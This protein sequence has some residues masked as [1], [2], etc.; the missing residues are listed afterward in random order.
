MGLATLIDDVDCREC[1]EE[2]VYMDVKEEPTS[3]KIGAYCH[4]C[5][6]DYG[7][8]TKVSRT[9]AHIDEIYEIGEETITDI[10]G[11]I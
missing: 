11:G 4:N 9:T 7:V 1:G 8:V 3:Y 5:N 6:H 2:D 10:L